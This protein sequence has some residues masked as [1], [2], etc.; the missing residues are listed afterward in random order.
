MKSK[1]ENRIKELDRL[2]R[3]GQGVKVR[4]EI[5]KLN[6]ARVPREEKLEYAS[7]ARRADL[8]DLAVRILNPIVHPP[9]DVPSTAT[10]EEKAE[11]GAA[12]I[13][14]GVVPEALKLLGS[15]DADKT[16]SASLFQA[17][18]LI[19][20]W[21]YAGSIP[22][23]EKLISNPR[24]DSYQKVICKG[25]LGA[26]LVHE[27]RFKEAESLLL[28][29]EKESN[30][31]MPI[32][33]G[34]VLKYLA[35]LKV[36]TEEFEDA[37]KLLVRAEKIVQQF[38]ARDGFYI[39]KWQTVIDVLSSKGSAKALKSLEA[40]QKEALEKQYYETVRDCDFIK[41]KCTHD[42]KTLC[43]LYFGTP[44]LG[45]KKRI[46]RDWKET[47]VLPDQ[48]IW[49]LNGT[50]SKFPL[51]LLEGE[52]LK[53][54]QLLHRLVFTLSSDFYRP[55]RITPLFSLLFPEEHFNPVTSPVKVH[56][57]IKRLRKWF[58]KEGVPLQILEQDQHYSFSA[59]SNCA[60]QIPRADKV[61]TDAKEFAFDVLQKHFPDSFSITE[62]VKVLKTSEDTVFRVLRKGMDQGVLERFGKAR[63]T[64]YR[65]QPNP[66]RKAA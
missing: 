15:L 34:N 14:I 10:Q 4:Q 57:V 20:Q 17:L 40:I 42:F 44:F 64:R 32:I 26:A 8:A 63:A 65:F 38:G 47:V 2:I 45:Y 16:P 27:R 49:V 48:Y 61:K 31:K 66:N 52:G 55:F 21:D 28:D 39:R 60:L 35:E 51:K 18:G 36:E 13:K 50:S 19:A 29:L 6:L 54:G 30:G 1:N 22:Y 23:L 37:K 5:L 58:L 33:H 43:H 53:V 59:K 11:Y 9:K 12:L 24:V 62:A 41:A 7:L 3:E 46:L 25:N 56:T